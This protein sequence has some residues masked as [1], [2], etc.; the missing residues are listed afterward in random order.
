MADLQPAHMCFSFNDSVIDG[1]LYLD[2]RSMSL[3]FSESLKSFQHSYDMLA[4]I[5]A[6]NAEFV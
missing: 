4:M 2:D 6:S 3:W 5:A 1:L